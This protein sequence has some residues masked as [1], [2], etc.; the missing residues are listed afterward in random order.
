MVYNE[1]EKEYLRTK[2]LDKYGYGAMVG[3]ANSL[4]LELQ[5]SFE[6]VLKQLIKNWQSVDEA[7]KLKPKAT[8]AS[9]PMEKAVK[10]T[11]TENMPKFG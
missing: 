3:Q 5:L 6:D 8:T 4:S 9:K 10:A 11:P 2:K 7:L 1:Q